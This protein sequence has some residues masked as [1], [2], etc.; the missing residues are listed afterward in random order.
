VHPWQHL[1]VTPPPKQEN[2]STHNRCA[3]HSVQVINLHPWS[4]AHRQ[5]LRNTTAQHITPPPYVS[6]W[7]WQNTA[8]WW[9][10][11]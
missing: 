1:Q 3:G 8:C 10:M 11:E 6:Q 9:C 2:T 5:L 4:T 7:P